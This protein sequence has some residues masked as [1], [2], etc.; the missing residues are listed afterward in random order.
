MR[1]SLIN[2]KFQLRRFRCRGLGKVNREA[3]WAAITFD[4]Q[5]MFRLAPQP[6]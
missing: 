2:E 6:A 1:R 3:I 5:R 4:L